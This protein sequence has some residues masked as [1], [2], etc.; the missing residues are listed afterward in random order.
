MRSLIVAV[1]FLVHREA[2]EECPRKH[3]NSLNRRIGMQ[4]RKTTD[5]FR[6]CGI[7]D[8]RRLGNAI[9]EHEDL[10]A[11]ADESRGF[12]NSEQWLTLRSE[13]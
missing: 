11:I 8:L 10:A 6:Q 4:Q 3:L 9:R 13:N 5:V 2:Y 1:K 12:K 7:L